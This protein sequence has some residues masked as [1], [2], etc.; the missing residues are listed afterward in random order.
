MCAIFQRRLG[1]TETAGWQDSHLHLGGPS[2]TKQSSSFSKGALYNFCQ[3]D[4]TSWLLQ[5]ST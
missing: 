3:E 1:G 5:M 2:Q 4:V